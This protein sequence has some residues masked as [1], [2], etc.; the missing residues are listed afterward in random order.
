[1]VPGDGGGAN[2]SGAALD[3]DTSILYVPSFSY[4]RLLKVVKP[5]PAR[6]DHRYVVS[7]GMVGGPDGLP[8]FKPPYSS[9]TAIDLKTGTHA[10]M[11]PMGRGME[12]HRRLEG[13][14]IPPTGG[15]GMSFPLAT[16]TLLLA[17]RGGSL[18]AIDKA[19]GK[20]LGKVEFKG[21]DGERLGRVSGAPMTYMHRG[22]QYIAVALTQ[23][24]G[25][26]GTARI[27]ALALP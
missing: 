12:N 14:N 13:L 27:V 18:T 26:R 17:G 6:S 7:L 23:G 11:T 9:I 15:M 19:T 16:K 1:M 4:T 3:P 24:G 22:K 8:L 21:A 2:F 10:W 25:R 5:D 20:V